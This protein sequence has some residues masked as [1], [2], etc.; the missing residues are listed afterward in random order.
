MQLLVVRF[1]YREVGLM[2]QESGTARREIRGAQLEATWQ[3]GMFHTNI[4]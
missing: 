4:R 3:Q 1:R 2:S